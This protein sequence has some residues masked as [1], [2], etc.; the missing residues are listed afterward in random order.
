MSR[1][2]LSG[3]LIIPIMETQHFRHFTK[4]SLFK[5]LD[6]VFPYFRKER[7]RSA[8]LFGLSRLRAYHVLRDTK[9]GRLNKKTCQ[10]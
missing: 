4:T 8:P 7:G 5:K 3:P 2:G 10:Q 9:Y 1:F 6:I